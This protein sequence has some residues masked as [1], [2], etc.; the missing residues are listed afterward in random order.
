MIND[1]GNYLKESWIRVSPQE[2]LEHSSNSGKEKA[3]FLVAKAKRFSTG[4][5][6]IAICSSLLPN[7]I[8]MDKRNNNEDNKG[9]QKTLK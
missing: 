9:I 2:V 1:G 3:E 4:N 8:L 7:L 6:K 5:E